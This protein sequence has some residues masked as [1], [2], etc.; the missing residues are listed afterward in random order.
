[1]RLKKY[2]E[3][4][5]LATDEKDST[6]KKITEQNLDRLSIAAMLAIPVSMAHIAIFWSKLHTGSPAD[7]LWR[8]DIIRAHTMLSVVLLAC[9]ISIFFHRRSKQPNGWFFTI[10]PHLGFSYVAL[11]YCPS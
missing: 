1:V 10:L 8:L 4:L 9:Y 6:G 5:K 7:Y 11:Y 3:G 2:I